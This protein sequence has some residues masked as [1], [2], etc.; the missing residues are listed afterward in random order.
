[1]VKKCIDNSIKVH[2]ASDP[3]T[4]IYLKDEKC[5]NTSNIEEKHDM[6]D[7]KRVWFIAFL[8][9]Y[10][11][12]YLE[13]GPYLDEKFEKLHTLPEG[14]TK[15]KESPSDYSPDDVSAIL[16]LMREVRMINSMDRLFG[17]YGFDKNGKELNINDN[18]FTFEMYSAWRKRHKD[19][20]VKNPYEYAKSI[21]DDKYKNKRDICY[22]YSILSYGVI[23][24]LEHLLNNPED[25]SKM[26]IED[27]GKLDYNDYIKKQVY[28]LKFYN[29]KSI[30]IFETERGINKLKK[31][32]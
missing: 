19:E 22:E 27:T 18:P 1:M 31:E 24:E 15:H 7:D 2:N 14:V 17:I 8:E 25:Y 23:V 29:Q 4:A 16:S 30:N 12:I 6:S 21:Y 5:E 10:N 13:D 26:S 9:K 20:D 28:A 3:A 32:I 11:N